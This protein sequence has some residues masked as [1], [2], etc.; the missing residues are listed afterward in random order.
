MSLYNKHPA[1]AP[2]RTRF[3][4]YSDNMFPYQFKDYYYNLSYRTPS[5]GMSRIHATKYISGYNS[6]RQQIRTN[7]RRAVKR[8]F[9]TNDW[10]SADI[11]DWFKTERGRQ[12]PVFFGQGLP[13][14]ISLVCELAVASG[15][16]TTGTVR[17]WAA[18]HIGID[19][20]GFVNAYLTSLGTF[21]Q[22]VQYH[23]RYPQITQ[24]ARTY[25]E[26]TYDSVIVMAKSLGNKNYRVKRNPKEDGAHIMV[27]DYWDIHGSSFW[28]TDQPGKRHPGPRSAIYDI[29]ES[30]PNNASHNLDYT[31]RI[32]RRGATRSKRVYITRE[33]QSN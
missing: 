13:E 3:F 17:D 8:H 33:M 30:P 12:G 23:P 2:I 20:N 19:C 21:S 1:L 6:Y 31:W 28:A 16:K 9:K 10:P 22:A 24:A 7:W 29:V 15:F 18:K 11:K 4:P 27:I 25:S 14:E 5:G 26:I 32:K